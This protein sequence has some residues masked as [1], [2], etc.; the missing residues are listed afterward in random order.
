MAAIP[1]SAPSPGNLEA[2]LHDGASPYGM[3][4]MALCHQHGAQR[5]GKGAA[6][7]FP[8]AAP[9]VERCIPRHA[10]VSREIKRVEAQGARRVD[11]TA[12][13][14]RAVAQALPAVAHRQ[15]VEPGRAAAQLHEGEADGL[16]E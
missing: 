8:E 10:A 3:T 7:H 16:V 2:S 13:Q 12:D 11:A 5:Q 1:T 14:C 6:R 9:L 15:L 4:V